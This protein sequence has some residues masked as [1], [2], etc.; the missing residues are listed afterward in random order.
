MPAVIDVFRVVLYAVLQGTAGC[1]VGVGAVAVVDA[2]AV[3]VFYAAEIPCVDVAGLVSAFA[4][5]CVAVVAAPAVVVGVAAFVGY[6]PA[7]VRRVGTV[8]YDA[9][10]AAFYSA[11]V[12]AFVLSRL[13]VA[14]VGGNFQ[15]VVAVLVFFAADYALAVYQVAFAF[16]VWIV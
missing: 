10:E 15:D 12:A 2:V 1:S 4:V 7:V 14:V 6:F 5:V 11:V 9:F 16:M 3:G 8:S 13:F